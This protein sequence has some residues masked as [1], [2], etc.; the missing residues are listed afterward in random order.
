[1]LDPRTS[2]RSQFAKING[3]QR[4]KAQLAGFVFRQEFLLTHNTEIS[5]EHLRPYGAFPTVLFR[6]HQL[7]AGFDALAVKCRPDFASILDLAML[8]IGETGAKADLVQETAAS[9]DLSQIG[10]AT[11]NSSHSCA[12]RMPSSA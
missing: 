3:L 8:I 9:I 10:R 4:E 1:M 2:F 7:K 12:S 6:L 11:L 5:H